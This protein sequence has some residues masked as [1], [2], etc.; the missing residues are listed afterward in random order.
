MH[1]ETAAA[2]KSV[3][4]GYTWLTYLWVFGISAW[5]GIVSYIGK[6]KRKITTRFS[7]TE[8][9]GEIV[10]SGFVGIITFWLCEWSDL[11]ELVTAAFVAIS[12]HM[13]ARAIFAA[14]RFAERAIKK[15]YGIDFELSAETEDVK[16][17]E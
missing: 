9:V 10:T 4:A 17:K 11:H 12:G 2:T 3:L 1:E 14:E 16:V 13:G 5:G 8:L 7:F 6:V 15:K